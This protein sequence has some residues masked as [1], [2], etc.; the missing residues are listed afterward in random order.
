MDQAAHFFL[1]R[2]AE[3]RRWIENSLERTLPF[4][5]L[6]YSLRDGVA[7]CELVNYYRPNSV[8]VIHRDGDPFN[9][10][11]NIG[12]FLQAAAKLMGGKKPLF[13]VA[14]LF[15]RVDMFK[16]VDALRTLSGSS[17]RSSAVS[18][19]TPPKLVSLATPFFPAPSSSR[20]R[21]TARTL[22]EQQEEQM[23]RSSG[24]EVRPG[25]AGVAGARHRT[26]TL[27]VGCYGCCCYGCL[28]GDGW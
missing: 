7:L 9:M 21:M 6:H 19:A 3:V 12:H 20:I 26:G 1:K 8:R 2:Q 25:V 18:V 17:S 27:T 13:E 15:D 16:V 11:R 4:E 14:D 5:D 23:Y 24:S 22:R 28:W 10:M